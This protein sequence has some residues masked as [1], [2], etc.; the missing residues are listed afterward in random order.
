MYILGISGHQR[1]AA[2]ALLKDGQVIAAIEEEK[3][4]RVKR[5]GISQCGGL[6]YES[7]GYCLE[8]AGVGIDDIDYVTYYVK[9][10]RLLNRQSKFHKQFIPENS[11]EAEDHKA[12]SVNEYHDR[13]KTLHLIRRLSGQH[14]KVVAVDHQLAHA[15][16]SFYLS[17]FDR[18]AILILS[19]KGDYITIAAGIGAGRK[20]GILRRVEFPHSLGWV[21]SLISDYLGFRANGGEHNTQWLSITGEPEFLP[22]FQ[23]LLKIDAAGIPVTDISYFTTCLQGADPFS[24]KFYQR[25]G[26]CLRRKDQ[27]F[28][29]GV[30]SPSWTDLIEELTVRK[31]AVFPANNYRRNMAHSLQKHLE[32][33][34]LALAESVRREYGVDALCLAGGVSSNSLLVSRLER[35]S[36]YKHIFVQPA[37]GNAGCSVGAALFQWHN[38]LNQ[39]RPEVLENVFLGP[40]Y[41]DQEVKPVLDNCK[42]AYRYIVSEDKLLDEVSRLLYQGNI[43]AW[44][45]GRAEFGP[46]SL[47]ARSILATPLLAHMKENLNLFVKHRETSRPFAASVPEERAEEFF[48]NCGPLSRFLLALSRVRDDKRPLVPAAWC[49]DGMARVHTVNR[50]TNPLFWRLLNK[51]GAKTGVPILVNTS[52]NLF[53]EPI[54]CTP[55][56]AVR[57]FFCSGID[58]LVINNFLIQ[59]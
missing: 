10:R 3:L 56:E 22:A 28:N 2:S 6:P 53:G 17:G 55:R 1:D 29:G 15:A 33:A 34:V 44:F 31:K 30:K 39:G 20:I 42:L 9:P 13:L 18:A 38:Q 47:G 52:F 23:D 58:A 46:R 5:I 41:S 57:G 40:E 37:A 12:A 11:S 54:V 25:F 51:F 19:G 45:Q 59:K 21:Y 14:A 43:V 8:S 32:H 26:D 36:G 16:S 35:E 49:S 24:E 7:I 27:R 4:V 50:K 48:E